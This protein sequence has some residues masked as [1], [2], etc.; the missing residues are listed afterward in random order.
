MHT[1]KGG[2]AGPAEIQLRAFQTQQLKYT[3]LELEL[4]R[5]LANHVSTLLSLSWWDVDPRHATRASN[6]H[7]TVPDSDTGHF[8][9]A[10][11][12]PEAFE[13]RALKQRAAFV[14]GWV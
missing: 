8:L 11:W 13:C 5:L 3:L 6:K 12:S 1:R 14:I 4:P 2:P 10:P 7:L 9:P